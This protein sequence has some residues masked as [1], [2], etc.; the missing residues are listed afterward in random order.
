MVVEFAHTDYIA[1]IPGNVRNVNKIVDFP[2]ESGRDAAHAVPLVLNDAAIRY[3]G[4]RDCAF[5]LHCADPRECPES[6]RNR[7]LSRGV[8]ARRSVRGF[9]CIE[10]R[11]DSVKLLKVYCSAIAFLLPNGIQPLSGKWRLVAEGWIL[12]PL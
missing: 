5:R 3:S 11:R 9:P 1:Q 10:R 2:G 8:G 6:Q 12:N 4:C 7:W